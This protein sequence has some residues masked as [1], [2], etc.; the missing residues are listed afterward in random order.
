M[1]LEEHSFIS[2]DQS[3]YLKRHSTQTCLHRVIDDWLENVNA[4][5][6]TGGCLLDSSNCF[7]STNHTI[8]LKKFEMYGITTIEQKWFFSYI[9]GCK[10]NF[11]RISLWY[12]MWRST[13]VGSRP[14]FVLIIYQW[15]LLLRCRSLCT[16]YMYA[17]DVNIYSS[18]TSKDELERSLQGNLMSWLLEVN[19]N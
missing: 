9:R 16:K 3:A 18:A 14:N 6:I 7:D 13:G 15:Y 4:C 5:A 12:Y 17:D 11:T 1:F 10:S 8:W 19:G 2:M